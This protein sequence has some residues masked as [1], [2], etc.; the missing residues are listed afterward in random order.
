M[1][2]SLYSIWDNILYRYCYRSFL[3]SGLSVN[4]PFLM[5]MPTIMLI[6]V[7]IITN[8][9]TSSS[10]FTSL[11]FVIIFQGTII[12]IKLTKIII[13]NNFYTYYTM[14]LGI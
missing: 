6:S 7:L 10:K 11:Y 14:I 8:L 2:T 1:Y 9:V 4:R 12:P 3:I 13:Y 5:A